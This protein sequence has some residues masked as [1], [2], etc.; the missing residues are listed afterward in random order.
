MESKASLVQAKVVIPEMKLPRTIDMG[1]SDYELFV[2][3]LPEMGDD[4]C[5]DEFCL[6]SVCKTYLCF[7]R[8]LWA[9][10]CS[11]ANLASVIRYLVG[12]REL[13]CSGHWDACLT[14]YGA[15]YCSRSRV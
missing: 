5:E 3:H 13:T 7:S 11:E 8:L 2:C 6:H 1:L 9:R 14:Y 10:V 12:C 4:V 15:G